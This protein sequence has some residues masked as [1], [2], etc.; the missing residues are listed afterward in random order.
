MTYDDIE[1]VQHIANVSWQHTYNGII[2]EDVQQQFL[3]MAYSIPMLQ[4]RMEKTNMLLAEIDGHVVGFAAFTKTDEDGDAELTAI[5]LLPEYQQLGIGTQLFEAGL[6]LIQ[7]AQQLFVYIEC[8]N[9]NGR[10][11]YEAKG[12]EFVEEFE[13]LFQG[14]PLDTAQ[15][16][17][18]VKAPAFAG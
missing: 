3:N 1:I 8:D 15:Y 4:K 5:Y 14:Y 2:P 7:D 9:V 13:E 6:E 12:F 11:F 17:Y 10:N 18:Y 16:V